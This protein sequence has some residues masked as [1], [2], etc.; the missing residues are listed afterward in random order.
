MLL[1]VIVTVGAC[2]GGGGVEEEGRENGKAALKQGAS[3]RFSG[4][5]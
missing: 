1:F 5:L 3:P 4:L 2:V